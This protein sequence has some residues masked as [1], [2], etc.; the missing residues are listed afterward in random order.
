MGNIGR[1]YAPENSCSKQVMSELKA[2]FSSPL[3]VFVYGTLKP[4]E[5]YYQQYCA[6]KVVSAKGAIA[7]GQL[8]S[9]PVGYPAMTCGDSIVYGYL[10]E[11]RD[12]NVLSTLDALED[13]YPSRQKSKN[14]YNREQVDIFDLQRK[15]QGKAWVY[16]MSKYRVDQLGGKP[17][18]NSWWSGVGIAPPWE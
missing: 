13:Y 4:G 7:Y 1:C 9:L 16:L 10:L 18:G 8:F 11:F 5:A 17:Q 15:M 2:K 6:G 3:R 14:L 12:A